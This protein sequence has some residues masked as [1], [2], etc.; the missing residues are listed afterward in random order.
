MRYIGKRDLSTPTSWRLLLKM[1]SLMLHW[2]VSLVAMFSTWK[3]PLWSMLREPTS[4][5]FTKV[6]ACMSL[7]LLTRMGLAINMKSL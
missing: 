1:G 3:L 4:R 5:L 7:C 2:K 6:V